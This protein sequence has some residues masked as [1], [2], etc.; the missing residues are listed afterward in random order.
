MTLYGFVITEKCGAI[1]LQVSG[2]PHMVY[3]GYSLNEA[4][5]RYR[6]KN[7]LKYKHIT[8]M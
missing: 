6:E 4:K 7:D 8:W 5:K 2:H 3:I 1:R